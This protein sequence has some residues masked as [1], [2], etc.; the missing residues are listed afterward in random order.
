VSNGHRDE[1][2][3]RERWAVTTAVV[4]LSCL[5]RDRNSVSAGAKVGKKQRP[6]TA[7]QVHAH[8]FLSPYSSPDLK[9]NSFW[10][11]QIAPS[12]IH[13]CTKSILENLSTGKS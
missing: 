7:E 9:A 4:A 5:L 6:H 2:F 10:T 1:Q 3:L 8:E 12:P 11:V 13:A